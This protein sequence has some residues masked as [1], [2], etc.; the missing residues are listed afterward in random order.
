LTHE[1]RGLCHC[2][3]CQWGGREWGE[4]MQSLYQI[5]PDGRSGILRWLASEVKQLWK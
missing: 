4:K 1:S 5:R 2:H 3:P